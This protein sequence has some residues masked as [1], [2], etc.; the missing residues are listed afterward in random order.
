MLRVAFIRTAA[1]ARSAGFSRAS[2]CVPRFALQH[3]RYESDQ[4]DLRRQLLDKRDDLQRDWDAKVIAYDELKPKTQQPSPD[5]YL[6]DVREPDEVLQ[7]SI[8]SAVNLPLSELA[9]ALHIG[10]EEF[11][12]KYGFEKPARAQEVTFFCR[13]GKRSTT[14]C[15]VAKRNG[16]TKWA[17]LYCKFSHVAVSNSEFKKDIALSVTLTIITG[18]TLAPS[19]AIGTVTSP[20][21]QVTH[22]LLTAKESCELMPRLRSR[23]VRSDLSIQHYNQ[24]SDA[25]MDRLL[26]SLE[27]IVDQQ[28]NPDFEVEY[29]SGVLTLKL[30]FKGTYVINKQPPN[31]QIWLSSP[32]SG[33]KRYDYSD[34][35]DDWIYSRDGRSLGDLLNQELSDALGSPVD[36]GL[37]DVSTQVS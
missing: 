33:P 27:D 4:A 23:H 24:Y 10:R 7:G 13:S 29:S 16:Y 6:I 37:K 22:C 2:A 11:K 26:S 32:F 20:E 5:K 25:T 21:P 19:R 8:P 35:A 17:P 12:D 30:G 3:V 28:S 18:L 9:T 1:A 34:A 15:D 31:K 14:A 36:L